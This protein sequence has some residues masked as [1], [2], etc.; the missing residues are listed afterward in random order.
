MFPSL[1]QRPA[2]PT[3]RKRPKK[4]EITAKTACLRGCPFHIRYLTGH[5]SRIYSLLV[6]D[7]RQN[8][9][10]NQMFP[11]KT[12]QSLGSQTAFAT[13]RDFNNPPNP[14]HP[15]QV[16]LSSNK[17][18]VGSSNYLFK[19]S[20]TILLASRP[21]TVKQVQLNLPLHP[22]QPCIFQGSL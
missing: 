18:M 9:A 16:K 17:E 19:S 3:L 15:L 13:A 21:L 14:L 5:Q 11:S 7:S 22:G 6:A 4:D 2:N 20:K 8:Q 12:F 1:D 10:S